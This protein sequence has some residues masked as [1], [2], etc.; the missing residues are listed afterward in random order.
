MHSRRLLVILTTLA[1]TVGFASLAFAETLPPA[2][3][4]VNLPPP[5]AKAFERIARR[6]D[7]GEVVGER[8]LELHS[9]ASS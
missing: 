8:A 4:S 7:G 2:P 6:I 9:L 1:A 3:M 5:A